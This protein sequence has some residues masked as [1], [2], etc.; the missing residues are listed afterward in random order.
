MNAWSHCSLLSNVSCVAAEAFI[1]CKKSAEIGAKLIE[2]TRKYHDQVL[3]FATKNGLKSPCE[4]KAK[5]DWIDFA[6]VAATALAPPKQAA[7]A[8]QHS[9]QSELAAMLPKVIEYDADIEAPWTAQDIRETQTIVK[10]IDSIKL[11]WKEWLRSACA[12]GLDAQGSDLAAIASVFRGLHSHGAQELMKVDVVQQKNYSRRWV[13]VS[14]DIDKHTL[15]MA[16]CVPRSGKVHV[17]SNHPQ[18]VAIYVR[19]VPIAPHKDWKQRRHFISCTLSS[20]GQR[21][22]T[23]PQTVLL[24]TRHPVPQSRQPPSLGKATRPCTQCGQSD[25]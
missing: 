22:I 3:D 12:Q 11:P 13:V 9:A 18:R 20:K 23:R 6:A 4:Y 19:R 2:A 10:T 5:A 16:P 25:A 17:S 21:R 8:A 24:Q 7:A 1:T 15:E 14:E